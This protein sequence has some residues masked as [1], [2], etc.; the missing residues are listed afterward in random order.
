LS[1]LVAASLSSAE[2]PRFGLSADEQ[3]ILDLTNKARQ[4]ND[5]PPLK[6]DPVLTK[7]A[8]EHSA[9]M[10]EK[11]EMNHVLDGLNPADRVKKADYDFSLVGENIA[12]AEN[13]PLAEVF[14]GWMDSKPHRENI[15]R[16]D[17]TSIGL[18][19]KRNAKGE[20]YYT[21]VFATPRDKK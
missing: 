4:K 8:R 19:L 13:T 3:Q 7:V 2:P 17:F 14:Q 5:L 15:L 16:K 12:F 18:G 21:Q 11:G 20:I 1:L 10:A 6:I 9:R